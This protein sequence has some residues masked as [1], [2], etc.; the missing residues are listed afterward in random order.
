VFPVE[1]LWCCYLLYCK[2][3]FEHVHW[4]SLHLCSFNSFFYNVPFFSSQYLFMPSSP[5]PESLTQL[6]WPAELLH[7]IISLWVC[8]DF[9]GLPSSYDTFHPWWL[10]IYQPSGLFHDILMRYSNPYSS[11]C[12][13]TFSA[14]QVSSSMHHPQRQWTQWLAQIEMT[15]Q[16]SFHSNTIH[17]Y[18]NYGGN[19]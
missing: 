5:M 15:S 17:E 1:M 2:S 16:G 10:N 14:W 11:L 3:F 6:S 7:K 19:E 12:S 13:T 8:K 4:F 18:K 9:F